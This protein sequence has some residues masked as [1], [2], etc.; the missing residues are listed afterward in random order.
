MKFL[1]GKKT[2]FGAV[3]VFVAGGL[4]AL[5]YIDQKTFEW[6]VAVGGSITAYGMR[7]A[8]KRM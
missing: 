5:G 1:E 3:V 2:Y 8:I 4:L 7:D 6:V